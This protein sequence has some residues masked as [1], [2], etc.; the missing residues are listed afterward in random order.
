MKNIA[1]LFYVVCLSSTSNVATT[2]LLRCCF[3]CGYLS[4]FLGWWY[5]IKRLY[6][7]SR[8]KP[9]QDQAC[10]GLEF[11]FM[12]NGLRLKSSALHYNS[13]FCCLVDC[14]CLLSRLHVFWLQAGLHTVSFVTIEFTIIH[15]VMISNCLH[16]LTA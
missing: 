5:S 12:D 11:L 13:S 10:S 2:G 7:D 14:S 9:N 4:F 1:K 16:M 15:T 8:R 3:R 6:S